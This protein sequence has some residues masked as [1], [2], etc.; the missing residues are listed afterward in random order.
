ML[1]MFFNHNPYPLLFFSSQHFQAFDLS[2]D[3]IIFLT[4]FEVSVLILVPSDS[5]SQKNYP[6]FSITLWFNFL[7][8]NFDPSGICFV[9]GYMV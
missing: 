8:L 7:Y 4:V 5:K 1:I 3:E 9:L 2:A 6:S